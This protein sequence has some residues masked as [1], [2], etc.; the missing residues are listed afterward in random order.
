[1]KVRD[2]FDQCAMAYDVDRPK[3]VPAFDELY[4][5][6]MY[7]IP[8]TT[9]AKIQVL[10]LGAGTGLFGAMVAKAF[11]AARLHLTDIS[12]AMLAQARQRFEGNPHVTYSLQEHSN[13][14]ATS[15]Y[16]LVISALS[17]H[18]LEDSDKRTLFRKIYEA[19]HPSG[20]FIN[21]DQA[22]APTPSGEE[23][24]ERKWLEDVKANGA[25]ELTVT[26]ARE[27]MREDKSAL[28]ADQLKWLD[29]AG[30]EDIDCWYKRFRF[31]VYGARKRIEHGAALDGNSAVLHCR[32]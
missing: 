1:M 8:F 16:D 10:D 23:R 12:E 5:T 31:V 27:R 29:E 13:L 17:I 4:G 25:S 21:V 30:F 3:L 32:Q 28:L 26:Q 14:S 18:H 15:E 7:V 2:L 20:M 9:D 11:P 6:A 19:L 24:Y 22:L